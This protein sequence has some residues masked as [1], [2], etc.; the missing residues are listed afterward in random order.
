MLGDRL[1][2]RLALLR[3]PDR[4]LE[5]A[6]RDA[7]RARGHVDAADLDRGHVLHEPLTFFPAEQVRRREPVIVERDLGRLDALVAELL[8]VLPDDHAARFL[9][10]GLLLDDEHRHALVRRVGVGGLR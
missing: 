5:R 3:V 2:E 6:L 8:D 4:L 1:A 7:E 10:A 9:G